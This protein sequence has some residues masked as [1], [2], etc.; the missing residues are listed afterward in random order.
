M[1]I[2]YQHDGWDD[3]G[4]LLGPQSYQSHHNSG[5]ITHSIVIMMLVVDKH[6]QPTPT[7]TTTNLPTKGGEGKPRSHPLAERG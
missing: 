2:V 5:P 3:V 6:Q 4:L 7:S 1:L